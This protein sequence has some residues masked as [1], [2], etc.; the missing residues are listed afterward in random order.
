MFLVNRLPRTKLEEIIIRALGMANLDRYMLRRQVVESLPLVHLRSMKREKLEVITWR[1]V[2]R[3]GWA[4]WGD[5]Q[6][7]VSILPPVLLLALSLRDYVL[8]LPVLLLN[9]LEAEREGVHANELLP[10]SH[11]GD[12]QLC[13][14]SRAFEG[15]DSYLKWVLGCGELGVYWW[16][17]AGADDFPESRETTATGGEYQSDQLGFGLCR[18]PPLKIV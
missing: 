12:P 14:V 16:V 1:H 13:S 8:F 15:G 6:K 7:S 9:S 4:R 2:D 11:R 10:R 18:F 5:Y 3:V 17:E